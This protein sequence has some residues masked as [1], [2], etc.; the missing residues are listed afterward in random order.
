M[1]DQKIIEEILSKDLKLTRQKIL[2]ELEEEKQK[3][4]NLID[5]NTLMRIIA[6]RY[7]IIKN[8]K[9]F[10]DG[11]LFISDLISGLYSVS[12]K[13][14]VVAI[15]PIK[16]FQGINS[17][18]LSSLIISDKTALIRVI[19]WNEKTET[20]NFQ[21][22]T[23]GDLILI[24]RAYTREDYRGKVELHIGNKGE[25]QKI[26]NELD[27]QVFPSIQKFSKKIKSI[28]PQITEVIVTGKIK[29][30]HPIQ[31][32]IIDNS[33]QRALSFTLS[34][35]TGEIQVLISGE[36]ADITKK[37]L[38]TKSNL[39]IINAKVYQN[40]NNLIELHVNSNTY[41]HFDKKIKN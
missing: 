9:T 25:I 5:E 15:F 4:G 20:I 12:I 23:I 28:T 24:S 37:L 2:N 10:F 39:T 21:K 3:T 18:K 31:E 1:F 16:T 17:G 40:I 11:N 33:P 22:I 34:D 30:I 36:Q 13:G 41:L 26:N 19:L 29:E 27:K 35:E 8:Q 6:A 32:S 14:R 7:G 38:K